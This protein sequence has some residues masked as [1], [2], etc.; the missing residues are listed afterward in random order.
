[1][2]IIMNNKVLVLIYV[3][4]LSNEYEVLI[5]TNERIEKIIEKLK[6]MFYDLS[7]ANFDI[8]KEYN[9]IDSET[10]NAYEY[11]SIVRDT[12]ISYASKLIFL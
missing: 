5:P 11:G 10:G 7:D 6:K 4:Y 12:D 2:V 8:Q 3:P 1:M 9:L